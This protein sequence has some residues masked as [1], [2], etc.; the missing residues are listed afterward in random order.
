MNFTHDRGLADEYCK[1]SEECQ[2]SWKT[3]EEYKR[4]I[5]DAMKYFKEH[6]NERYEELD[7]AKMTAFD[8]GYFD[9]SGQE[10]Y[11]EIVTSSYSN[12]DI[13]SKAVAASTLQGNL[14]LIK[15]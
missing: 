10:Q 3:E 8:G 2:S 12:A 14:N 5:D 1:L 15:Y 4:E 6:D 13:E 11:I 9:E 7:S